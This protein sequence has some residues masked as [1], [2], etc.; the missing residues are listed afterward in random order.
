MFSIEKLKNDIL[1][2]GVKSGDTL[3][4]RADLGAIGRLET[5]KK[6][7]YINFILDV[8]GKDGTIVGLSFT[9]GFFVKRNKN[10]VFDGNNKSNTGA[11]S[12]T[13]LKHPKSIRSTHP[14][15]S[16]VAIGKNSEY[17]L[18]GH[19]EKSG[20]YDPIRKVMSLNGKMLLIGCVNSSP[21]F[22]TTHLAE[23]DLGLHKK[24][25]FP[26]LNGA[27]YKKNGKIKIFKRKD[28]GGPPVS[29]Y[30]SAQ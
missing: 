21:G 12:N 6:E 14:T 5:K 3:L 15:N 25:I 2:L 30:L 11:F 10:I 13:M 20:A 26:T 1:D 22:T 16:Y 28:Q 4:I 9:S 7:D 8:V 18:E 19:N 24:I 17:I 27:Y 29:G 23:I